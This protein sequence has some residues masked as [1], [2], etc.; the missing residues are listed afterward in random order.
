M[1]IRVI[2]VIDRGMVFPDKQIMIAGKIVFDNHPFN[3][4]GKISGG[5]GSKF[6][7][8]FSQERKSGRS[9]QK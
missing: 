3:T 4:N 6:K 7:N 5:A 1:V 2:P 9:T 8:T